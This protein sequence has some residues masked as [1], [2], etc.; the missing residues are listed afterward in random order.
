[1]NKTARQPP[2]AWTPIEDEKCPDLKLDAVKVVQKLGPIQRG[3][4]EAQKYKIKYYKT[5]F[6]PPANQTVTLSGHEEVTND[7]KWPKNGHGAVP[8]TTSDRAVTSVKDPGQQT[9]YTQHN[10]VFSAR[11]LK[12]KIKKKLPILE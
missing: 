2:G 12:R 8:S 4:R 3:N 11:M 6:T 10:Q 9:E 5:P 1:M 7:S